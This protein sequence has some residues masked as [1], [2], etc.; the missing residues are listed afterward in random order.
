MNGYLSVLEPGYL[1]FDSEEIR[2]KF[3]VPKKLIKINRITEQ[4]AGYVVIDTNYGEEYVDLDSVTQSLGLETDWEKFNIVLKGGWFMNT[5]NTAVIE[6]NAYIIVDNIAFEIIRGPKDKIYVTDLNDLR[7]RANFIEINNAL[8]LA[9]SSFGD[10]IR[11]YSL[12]NIIKNNE[13]R[14]LEGLRNA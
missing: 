7:N 10:N 12:Y 5:T 4:N 2:L 6:D 1:M 11:E 3:M 8:V 9:N 14:L 13:K